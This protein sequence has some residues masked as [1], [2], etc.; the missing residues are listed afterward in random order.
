MNMRIL[1]STAAQPS[2]VGLRLLPRVRQQFDPGARW[3]RRL[4]PPYG[5]A[6]RVEVM[7]LGGTKSHEN[8]DGLPRASAYG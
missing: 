3:H 5:R 1:L 7:P 6:R 2:Q 4:L 8:G